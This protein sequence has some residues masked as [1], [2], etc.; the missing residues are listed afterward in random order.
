MAGIFVDSFGIEHGAQGAA[1]VLNTPVTVPGAGFTSADGVN[2]G[3]NIVGHFGKNV[4]GPFHGYR[5][6]ASRFQILDFP[7]ARDTRC[8]GISDTLQIVGRYTDANGV[9][10]AFSAK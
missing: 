1:G 2:D 6:Q 5:F 10:H 3:I 8:N 9:V 7:H 4:A